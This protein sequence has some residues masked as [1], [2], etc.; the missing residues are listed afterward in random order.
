[1]RSFVLKPAS[2]VVPN[3]VDPITQR[4]LRSLADGLLDRPIRLAVVC[5]DM[6]QMGRIIEFLIQLPGLAK[7]VDLS[8]R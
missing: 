2:E 8:D 4:S 5:E 7:C 3:W 6:M 1:M